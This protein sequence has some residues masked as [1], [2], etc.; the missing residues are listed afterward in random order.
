[1]SSHIQ[2]QHCSIHTGCS[3]I[4]SLLTL[5]RAD[6]ITGRLKECLDS[7]RPHCRDKLLRW[8]Q[9]GFASSPAA[10]AAFIHTRAQPKEPP[11]SSMMRAASTLT[12]SDGHP[13]PNACLEKPTCLCGS[14][15]LVVLQHLLNCTSV[16]DA[17]MAYRNECAAR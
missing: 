9:V 13:P 5:P 7:R 6:I 2:K 1:M 8:I 11:V 17:S 12:T 15:S 3:S 16:A 14:S 4:I 10:H